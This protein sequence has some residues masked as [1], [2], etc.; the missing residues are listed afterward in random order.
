MAKAVPCPACGTEATSA[1]T[2]FG[3][4]VGCK[5]CGLSFFAEDL[6]GAIK[7]WNQ[8]CAQYAHERGDVQCWNCGSPT[9]EDANYC[10]HCGI[11]LVEE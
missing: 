1:S 5:H 6:D 7:K 8:H 9:S 4:L 2:W 3:V 11:K 10:G